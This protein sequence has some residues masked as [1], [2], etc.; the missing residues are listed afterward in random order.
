M[1]W[2]AAMRKALIATAVLA[3]GSLA[4]RLSGHL[5]TPFIVVAAVPIIAGLGAAGTVAIVRA[6]RRAELVRRLWP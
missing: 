2:A 3:I 5:P 6:K 4:I 1:L